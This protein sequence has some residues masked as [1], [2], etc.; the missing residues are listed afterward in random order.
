[1][2]TQVQ[3]HIAPW[4]VDS[5]DWFIDFDELVEK[6]FLDSVP[7]SAS[8]DNAPRFPESARE[9]YEGSYSWYVNE[10]GQVKSLYYYYPV[11]ENTGYQGVYP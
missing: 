1:M 8:Q 11:P 2:T 3:G 9:S 5:R 4:L 6:H 7:K 10:N